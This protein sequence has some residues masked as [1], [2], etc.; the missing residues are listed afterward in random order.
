[1][2]ARDLHEDG[3]AEESGDG[4]GPEGLHRGG[5]VPD[6]GR[7]GHLQGQSEQHLLESIRNLHYQSIVWTMNSMCF[8]SVS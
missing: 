8:L 2:G 4:L 1:M 3:G 5:D 6:A 7:G